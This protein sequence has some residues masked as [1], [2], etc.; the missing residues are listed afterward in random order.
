MFKTYERIS[1]SPDV[2]A[3]VSN[4]EKSHRAA[5]RDFAKGNNVAYASQ[6]K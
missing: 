1:Q 2:V 5:E 4:F 6:S 3:S